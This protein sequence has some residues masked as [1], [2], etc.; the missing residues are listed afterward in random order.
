[1]KK[2]KKLGKRWELAG[3]FGLFFIFLVFAYLTSVFVDDTHDRAFEAQAAS[4]TGAIYLNSHAICSGASFAPGY[5]LTARHCVVDE[6]H[7]LRGDEYISF[8]ANEQGPFYKTEIVAISLTDDI[9]I[10]RIVNGSNAP[11]VGLGD[12]RR[13]PAGHPILNYTYALDQGKMRIEGRFI[14]PIYKHLP[15]VIPDSYPEWNY[16]MPVDMTIAPGSS[17]SAIFDAFQQEIIGVVVGSPRYGGFGIVIPV[18]RVWYL[19]NHLAENSVQE[20]QKKFP[21]KEIDPDEFF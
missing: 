8:S 7:D 11:W 4:A 17:G 16:S 13:T 19:T 5:F 3:W 12:E 20:Y 9:A 1:M 21:H 14:E 6:Q 2:P 15:G 18:S 10:L